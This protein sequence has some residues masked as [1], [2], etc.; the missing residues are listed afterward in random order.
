MLR[1]SRILLNVHYRYS[2]LG[3]LHLHFH[4]PVDASCTNGRF[5]TQHRRRMSSFGDAFSSRFSPRSAAGL[6]IGRK[7][8]ASTFCGLGI[9]FG[10][11]TT[12]AVNA[13]ARA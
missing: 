4:D 6:T 13:V 9:A 12:V 8:A 2:C 5:A 3:F 1:G 10:C 7:L 11:A